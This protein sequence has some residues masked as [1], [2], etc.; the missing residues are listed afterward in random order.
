M[1]AKILQALR[2]QHGEVVVVEFEREDGSALDVVLRKPRV[3]YSDPKADEFFSFWTKR[4]A[5]QQAA[6]DVADP[7]DD[8]L[9]ECLRCVI[10]PAPLEVKQHLEDFPMDVHQ[11]FAAMNELAGAA[12]IADAP[13]L[14][15]EEVKAKVHRRAFGVRAG[16]HAFVVR[17]MTRF[18]LTQLEKRNGGKILPMHAPALALA[19]WSCVDEVPGE[20]KKKPRFDAALA[21][22][23]YLGI[24][25]G[26]MLIGLASSRGREREGK[27]L[28]P[29]SPP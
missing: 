10:E 4:T 2:E 29:S 12:A 8:G 27:S 17:P 24:Y 23:P 26:M 1:D 20:D 7:T 28:R 14:V 18:E 19:A 3:S 15:T 9:A 25:I 16:Q 22:V 6:Q 13:E 11:L 21:D 5:L